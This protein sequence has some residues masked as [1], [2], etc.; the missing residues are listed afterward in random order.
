VT[1]SPSLAWVL[2]LLAG[3]LEIVWSVSMKASDGFTRHH[4]TAITLVAAALSFW[5]LGLA[6]RQLPVGTAYA[7]WTGVG[8]V[9][10]AVL[11]IALFGESPSLLRIG[12]IALIVLG[13]LG[14]KFLGGESAG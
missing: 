7:V 3:L 12:C 10:A 6:L 11:G 2:L 4:F 14:L 5:L 9:G 8:A 13:I 1:L